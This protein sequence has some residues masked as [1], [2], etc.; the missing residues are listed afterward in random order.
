M[1]AEAPTAPPPAAPAAAPVAPPS[2]PPEKAPADYLGGITDELDAGKTPDK[3][4][5]KPAAPKSDAKPADKPVEKPAEQAKPEEKPAEVKPVKAAELRAAYDG[6]KKKVATEI[7]PELQRLRAK[8][9]EYETKPPEDTAPVLQKLKTLEDRNRQLE[10]RQE[11]LEFQGSEKYQ[12][13]YEQPYARLWN[14]AVDAFS[15]LRVKEPDGVVIDDVTGESKP[16]YKYRPAT[17][18]DLIKLGGFEDWEVDEATQS[19]F[20]A[21]QPRAVGYINELRK[22]VLKKQEAIKDATERAGQWKSQRS[23]EQQNLQKTVQ[24]A[25]QDINAGLEEKFPKAYQVETGN[26]EDA[27]AHTKGFAIA[28]L[29]FNEYRNG[30]PMTAEQVEALPARF[31]DTI[32]AGKPLNPVQKVQLHALARLKIANHDRLVEGRKKDRAR[33]AELEKSLSEYEQS[34]PRSGKAGESG[35]VSDKSWEQTV[36]DEI[37]AMDRQ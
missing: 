17:E 6:L 37:K 15:R 23:L 36:E 31:R 20:G 7:E 1:P 2:P 4:K 8:V 18:T 22:L 11:L 12:R 32:K 26:A 13:E 21:S 29:L 24:T 14:E 27:A 33:I 16:K 28:D 5:E 3:P 9:Q 19:M 25:W 30:T 34:E 10:Q 35:R